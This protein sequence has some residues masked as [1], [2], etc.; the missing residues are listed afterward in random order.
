MHCRME[1]TEVK[2][3]AKTLSFVR[4]ALVQDY[5]FDREQ[6]NVCSRFRAKGRR[7]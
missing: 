6:Y 2:T 7:L 1:M 4:V 5:P 3:N